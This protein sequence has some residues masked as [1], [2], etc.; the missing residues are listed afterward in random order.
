MIS[1]PMTVYEVVS[2]IVWTISSLTVIIS[3]FWVYRQTTIFAK[4]TDY[5]ARSLTLSLSESLNSQSHE[6]GRLFVEYPELRPYFY[7]SQTIDENHPHYA[8]AEAVAEL[9]LDIFWTMSSQAQ[10]LEAGT[11]GT[12]GGDNLWQEFVVDSFAES[13]ILVKTLMKR[14]NWYGPA[15]IEQMKA[16][17][18]RHELAKAA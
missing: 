3:L 18:K 11:L 8:R 1:Q 2:L 15:M 10:R 14:H 17:L 5:V 6:I 7:D 4:Q 16:G 13:P 12:A 9:I